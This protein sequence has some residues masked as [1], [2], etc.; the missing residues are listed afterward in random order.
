MMR[1]G[2]RRCFTKNRD[3]LLEQSPILHRLGGRFVLMI[4]D[5]VAQGK[6][7]AALIRRLVNSERVSADHIR[8]VTLFRLSNIEVEDTAGVPVEALC[9]L[10]EIYYAASKAD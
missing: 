8:Y 4:D 5:L 6:T 3:R 1:S 9:D 10:T 2:C 7:G